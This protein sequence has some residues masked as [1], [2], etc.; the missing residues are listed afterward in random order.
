MRLGEVRLGEVGFGLA[1][2]GRAA[3]LGLGLELDNIFWAQYVFVTITICFGSICFRQYVLG[4][5]VFT[6]MF[7]YHSR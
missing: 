3:Q 6:N 2:L 1:R 7:S 4:Q 5:Y